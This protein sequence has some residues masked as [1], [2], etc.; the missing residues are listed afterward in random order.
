M[1][2]YSP[3]GS[4]KLTGLVIVLAA[5][6]AITLLAVIAIA[7]WDVN[8]QVFASAYTSITTIGGA[9]QGAQAMADRSAFY[10]NAAP[11]TSPQGPRVP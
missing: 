1:N 6:V 7:I 10:S 8:W 4:R 3:S 5:L 9:H 2:L 11:S